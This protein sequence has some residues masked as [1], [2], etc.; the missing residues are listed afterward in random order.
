[1]ASGQIGFGHLANASIGSGTLASGVTSRF[2][3]ASGA[4]NSG[5]ISS[6]TILAGIQFVIDGGGSAITT[7]EKGHVEVPFNCELET[8]SLFGDRSGIMFLSLWKDTYANFPPTS[9]DTITT[10]GVPIISGSAGKNQYT[11]A[12]LSGWIKTFTK[13]DV[14]TF[15]VYSNS[16]GNQR[17]TVSL[18]VG[19]T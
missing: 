6:G 18:T 14:L 19:K 7:G 4:V 11:G 10:S 5:H 12:A 16:S 1:M 8:V 15:G 2:H 13:G 3:L 17:M 9:G